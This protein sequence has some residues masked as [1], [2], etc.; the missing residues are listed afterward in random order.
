MLFSAPILNTRKLMERYFNDLTTPTGDFVK[1]YEVSNAEYL[2]LLKFINAENRHMF[3]KILEDEVRKGFPEYDTVDVVQKVYILIG[4]VFY[5]IRPEVNIK[6]ERMGDMPVP[7]TIFLNNLEKGYDHQKRVYCKISKSIEV[8]VSFPVKYT[9]EDDKSILYDYLS[10][11]VSVRADGKEIELDADQR[12]ALLE[13]LGERERILISESAQRGLS[14]PVDLAEGYPHL[15]FKVD[16]ASPQTLEMVMQMF[17]ESLE[18]FY[19]T[20]YM[21][22]QY[23]K[24]DRRSFMEMTPL[25]TQIILN[26]FIEDKKRQAEEAN[27]QKNGIPTDKPT[28]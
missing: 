4:F 19:S 10:G 7:L 27:K 9:V 2:T 28:P 12:S 8:G 26:R 16:I 24:I 22:T 14:T 5:N 1:I 20:E 23:V 13:K 21:M 25:E 18:S 6:V 15:D 17:R 3:L 11:I